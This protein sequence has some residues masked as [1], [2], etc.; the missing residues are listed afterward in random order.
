MCTMKYYRAVKKEV[1]C[2]L[3]HVLLLS[4]FLSKSLFTLSALFCSL[5]GCPFWKESTGL[6][7]PLASTGRA[8]ERHLSPRLSLPEAASGWQWQCSSPKGQSP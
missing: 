3:T 7:C 8:R 2:T 4:V 1:L 6:H 5:K